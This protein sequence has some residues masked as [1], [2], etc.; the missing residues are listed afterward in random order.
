MPAKT[1][2]RVKTNLMPLFDATG[3][4]KKRSS[5]FLELDGSTGSART[6]GAPL[7]PLSHRMK[8]S[9]G[10]Q[11]DPENQP[12][13]GGSPASW[14]RDQV[15][16]WLRSIELKETYVQQLFEEEVNGAVLQIVSDEFLRNTL[17]M[18]LGPAL[19]LIEKRDELF[20]IC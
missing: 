1:T 16:A 14:T 20:G 13:E 17:R 12:V 10:T 2:R 3:P 7:S 11:T 18:K 9:K 8:T 19:W 15:K 4:T 5:S 6:R